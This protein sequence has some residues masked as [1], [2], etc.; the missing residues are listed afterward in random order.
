[1]IQNPYFQQFNYLLY[2]MNNYQQPYII[3]PYCL[4]YQNQ[5][6]IIN[7]QNYITNNIPINNNNNNFNNQNQIQN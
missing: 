1:M 5:I 2:Q 3:N 4:P 6:P 7:N